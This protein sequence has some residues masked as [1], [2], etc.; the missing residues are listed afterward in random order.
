MYKKT[1]YILCLTLFTWACSSP[2]K[3]NTDQTAKHE[4]VDGEDHSGH[5]HEDGEDHSGHDHEKGDNHSEG[6][7]DEVIFTPEQA[8]AVG[9]EV[10]TV[11]PSDFSEVIKTSGQVLSAPGDEVTISATINGIVSFSKNSITEGLAIRSGEPLINISSQRIAEGDPIQKAKN[12]YTV[13]E[14]EFKRAESLIK[15]KLISEKEYNG[16]KLDYENAKITYQSLARNY[17][18]AG[19]GISSPI[20]GYIKNKLVTEGQYVEIGQPLLTVTQNKKLQ[21]KADV[22]EKYYKNL[23]TI[24]SANFKTAYE[25]SVHKLSDLNGRLIS[26]GKSAN[27]E[28]YYVPINF[29]F[30]NIGDIVSGAYV[31]VYLL[32]SKKEKTIAIPITS[33]IE[34]QGAFFVFIQLDAEGYKKQEVKV[35]AN[36]G[37]LIQIVS[38]LH[39]GDKVVSKGAYH[40]KLASTSSAIPHGHEH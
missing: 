3:A 13:A 39:S 31:E 17:T 27:N 22:S 29:E 23:R 30:D 4:H 11:N 1:L 25:D 7:T 14:Q 2:D 34:E 6:G 21:L 36:D 35:G 10:I 37:Q 5:N 24:T 12:S 26:F 32:S 20:G 15:D 16:I 19:S 38:G 28:E 40:I 18:S 33:L 8:K 9:L